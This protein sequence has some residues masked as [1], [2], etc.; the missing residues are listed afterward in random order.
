MTDHQKDCDFDPNKVH[1]QF[2][3]EIPSTLDAAE[4]LINDAMKVVL[5]TETGRRHSEEI[6]LALREAVINAI[7]HG[8]RSDP[9]KKVHVCCACD[10]HD[11]VFLVV[12]DEGTG[13]DPRSLP[14]C[15]RPENLLATHGRGIF[16]INQLMDHVQFDK[17]GR[18][19]R[20]V[21]APHPTEPDKSD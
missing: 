15:T 19:I 6:E 1:L 17:G 18:E 3:R 16:L 2:E 9:H 20:M 21:K 14:D 8:N 11:H 7:V 12:Q 4:S 10:E 13:F 5:R